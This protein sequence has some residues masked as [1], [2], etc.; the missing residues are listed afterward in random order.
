MVHAVIFHL[1]AREAVEHRTSTFLDMPARCS[2]H[3]ITMIKGKI[4]N[5]EDR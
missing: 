2:E 1:I 4:V 3:S 5:G